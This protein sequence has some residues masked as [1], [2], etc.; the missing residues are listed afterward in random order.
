MHR[1]EPWAADEAE[2]QAA[3]ARVKRLVGERIEHV[4]YVELRYSEAR[5]FWNMAAAFDTLDFGCELGLA[6]GATWAAIWEQ[7]GHNEGLLLYGGNLAE[8]LSAEANPAVWDVTTSSRW[9]P[10]VG[11]SITDITL[12]WGRSEW[13]QTWPEPRPH[14]VSDWCSW[15]ATL[16]FDSGE[17]VILTLGDAN[18]DGTL[19]PAPDNVAIFFDEETAIRSGVF[20]EDDDDRW[21]RLDSAQGPA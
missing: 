9:A 18:N 4:R 8:R 11:R 21:K 12:Y 7:A 14:G 15:T 20:F 5:P 13:E 1:L 2:R 6:S 3:E 17:Q 19:A 10:V 16:H